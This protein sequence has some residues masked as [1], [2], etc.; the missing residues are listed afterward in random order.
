MVNILVEKE[1]NAVLR[2]W[3]DGYELEECETGY[4]IYLHD[5]LVESCYLLNPKEAWIYTRITGQPEDYADNKYCYDATSWSANTNY[6][7]EELE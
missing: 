5:E 3:G 7:K 4:E 2:S 6:V 1:T